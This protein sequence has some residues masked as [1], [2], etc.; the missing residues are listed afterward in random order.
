MSAIRGYPSQQKLERTQIQFVTVEPVRKEQNGASVVAHQYVFEVGTDAAEAGTT[1]GK[2]VAT[3]HAAAEGDVVQLTSG[4][5]SGKEI[6]V[7]SVSA[8]E[9]ILAEDLPA[10]IAVGVTFKILRHKYPSVDANGNVNV[11]AVIAEEALAPDGGALPA[12]AKVIAGY[13]G[14]AVQVLK[15]DA[16]GELQVDVLSSALPAGAATEAT[17]ANVATSANQTNGGQKSQIVDSAGDIVDVVLL[18]TG[19]Q[20]TDKG[21]VTNTVIHGQTTG[22]GGGY[23]DVKVTPSGAMVTDSTISGLDA[24]ILGQKTMANSLPVVLASNQTAIP[25]TDNGSSLTVDGSVSVSNFPAT[26]NVAVTSIVEVEIKNDSGSAV[27][28]SAASLPLPSG[29]ATESTLSSLNGKVTACN[30]GAV[31]ISSSALPTG[32]A[33]ESTLSSLNGKVTA[34]NTGAVVIS[35]SALPTGAATESTL[36]TLNGKVTACNTGAVT[37]SSA[38]PAGTNTIGAVNVNTLTPV[39]IARIDYTVTSVTTGAYVTL[40]ASLAAGVKEVQIFD[41]S[42]QTL[43]LAVG[44]AGS[45]VDR[46]YIIP[47]GNGRLPVTIAAASRVAIKAVSATANAG[48]IAV[49]FLG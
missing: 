14:A 49:N 34:C 45:E 11:N 36:S 31:T 44:G 16:A 6:K 41:S 18:S 24:A 47:G 39:D 20:A 27:P 23:V 12:K 7:I 17:L 3:A 30:T 5:Q 10:A 8:D 4:A 42:G 28:I 33:T 2:I 32:A 37:I 22:G 43:V 29:A 46:F 48:E 1:A 40:K 38:L 19:I 15:T 21:L 35:S 9:I 25:V 13:D 26:Q